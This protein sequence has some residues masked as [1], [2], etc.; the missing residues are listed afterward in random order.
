MG[1]APATRSA[2]RG[3][4]QFAARTPRMGRCR[5]LPRLL[6]LALLAGPGCVDGE[7]LDCVQQAIYHGSERPDLLR[8]P[9]SQQ[10]AIGRVT[11]DASPPGFFCTGT[12]IAP[13]RVLTARHC[14][15]GGPMRFDRPGAGAPLDSTRVALHP[16]L[17]V[18]LFA[19]PAAV[20]GVSA[21]PSLDAAV[22]LAP[23]DPVM[24]AGVGETEVGEVGQRR[25]VTTAISQVTGETVLVDGAGKSGACFGDSGGPVLIRD[26]SGRVKVA[27]VLSKGSA[28]CL[29]LD[30]AVRTDAIAAWIAQQLPA[31]AVEPPADECPALDGG[32]LC[33]GDRRIFCAAGAL[34]IEGC[35]PDQTCGPAGAC[36][37]R[38]AGC[39]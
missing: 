13:D 18:M 23:R 34:A 9:P 27:G 22:T 19:L 21:I 30:L 4:Y 33:L 6:G 36:V 3:K 15:F 8:L 24:L 35:P 38:P 29:N 25:F 10:G 2:P 20:T 5:F 32:G 14:H 26:T 28:S 37:P 31:T 1:A 39:R 12:L 16:D 11:T 7:V 17:D